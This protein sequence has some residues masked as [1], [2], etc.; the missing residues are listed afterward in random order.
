MIVI[1]ILVCYIAK[2]YIKK[3]LDSSKAQVKK[4]R[5]ALKK[6]RK[7]LTLAEK[8]L[9]RKSIRQDKII[10]RDFDTS[11]DDE[12]Q[13]IIALKIPGESSLSIS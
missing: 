4:K 13:S 9:A 3:R 10:E 1:I 11:K 8:Y 12:I 7:S 5:K 6:E 2:F